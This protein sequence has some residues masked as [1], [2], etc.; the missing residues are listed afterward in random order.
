MALA[1]LEDPVIKH[2]NGV[3]EQSATSCL[4]IIWTHCVPVAG[5]VTMACRVGSKHTSTMLDMLEPKGKAAVL[6]LAMLLSILKSVPCQKT[7]TDILSRHI[8][9][10][11]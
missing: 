5:A 6:A 4:L 10:K 7:L 1:L 2:L 3:C 8:Q 11:K 9:T